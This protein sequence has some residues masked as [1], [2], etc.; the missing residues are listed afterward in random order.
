[1]FIYAPHAFFGSHD[2]VEV[3]TVTCPGVEEFI[4]G[5]FGNRNDRG[6]IKPS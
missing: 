1:M 5:E 2:P 6:F 4:G 3:I